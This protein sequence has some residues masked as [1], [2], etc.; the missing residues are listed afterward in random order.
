MNCATDGQRR[1]LRWVS[2]TRLEI[3]DITGANLREGRGTALAA[4]SFPFGRSWHV[5]TP[6]G[7]RSDGAAVSNHVRGRPDVRVSGSMG[8]VWLGT[9]ERK[10]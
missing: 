4:L 5:R 9:Q 10:R 2:G 6:R 8:D 7:L 1:M 3:S